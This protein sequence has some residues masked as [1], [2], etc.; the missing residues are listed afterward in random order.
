MVPLF[1]KEVDDFVKI[2]NTHRIWEQKNTL[3][4]DGV[5][6]HIH[7]FPDKYNLIEQGIKD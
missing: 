4:S 6:N 5:P 3:L 1:Q 2:L 7:A